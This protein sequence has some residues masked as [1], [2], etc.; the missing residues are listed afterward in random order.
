[1]VVTFNLKNAVDNAN[2]NCENNHNISK[3]MCFGKYL[4]FPHVCQPSE[5]KETRNA[6]PIWIYILIVSL[7][8]NLVDI[9]LYEVY[10]PNCKTSLRCSYC[11]VD[12]CFTCFSI[13]LFTQFSIWS[14]L[15]FGLTLKEKTGTI[16]SDAS[17]CE[18]TKDWKQP[19]TICETFWKIQN[20]NTYETF[21][22]S[23]ICC[24]IAKFFDFFLFIFS[25]SSS[26]RIW[27]CISI[28][29]VLCHV[30]LITIST[31]IMNCRILLSIACVK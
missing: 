11:K 2:K 3:H 6:K 30:I 4:N 28:L 18:Q 10:V 24:T 29:W 7:Q 14:Y 16:V 9:F 31:I 19:A 21:H 15:Q 26:L 13:A 8:N 1:M 20:R 5:N 22:E 25:D 12:K 23:Q 17:T 27:S